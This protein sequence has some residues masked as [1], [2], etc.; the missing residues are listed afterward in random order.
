MVGREN[1][2]DF[3]SFSVLLET[4]EAGFNYLYDL[5][6]TEVKTMEVAKILGTLKCSANEN[7]CPART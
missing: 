6:H 2:E 7:V 4:W 3:T 5:N 1:M